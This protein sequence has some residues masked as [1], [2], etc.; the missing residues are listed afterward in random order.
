MINYLLAILDSGNY[1]FNLCRTLENKGYVFEVV[2]TPCQIAKSGCGY[3]LKFPDEY[4]D[5]VVDEAK[6]N[7]FKVREIYKITNSFA[8]NIYEKII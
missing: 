8:K 5:L 1:V 3:C 2:A 6:E 4:K 7:G